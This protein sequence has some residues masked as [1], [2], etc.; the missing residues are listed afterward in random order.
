M[1]VDREGRAGIELGITGVPET[2]LVGAD[3]VVRAKHAGPL[4]PEVG[5]TLLAQARSLP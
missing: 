3:G 4:T 2:Y 5:G 1:L